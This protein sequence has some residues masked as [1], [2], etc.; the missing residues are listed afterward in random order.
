[1]DSWWD[2]GEWSGLDGNDLSLYRI[3][4]PFCSEKGNWQ[5]EN[6]N[7]KKKPNSSKILYFDTY[8]CGNC[9]SYIMIFW[10]AGYRLHSYRTL[11]WPLKLNEHPDYIP[12]DIGRFW[13]QA[14]RNFRDGNWDAAAVMTRSALQLTLRVKGANGKSLKEEINFLAQKGELPPIMKEWSDNIRLLG[15]DSAH[16]DI[17]VIETNPN[18]VNDAIKFLDF[19]LEYTFDL[20]KR[21]AEYRARDK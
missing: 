19:L 1:M 13:L 9:A 6:R 8:K 7:E 17:G 16:P 2:L 5:L 3:E 18:D 12:S 14:H 21:I 15:N 20:P 4:C 11:P 10:S